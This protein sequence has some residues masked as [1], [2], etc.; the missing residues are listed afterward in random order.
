MTV[1]CRERGNQIAREMML[2]SDAL[3]ISRT[4]PNAR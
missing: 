3:V 2:D 4:A 1:S